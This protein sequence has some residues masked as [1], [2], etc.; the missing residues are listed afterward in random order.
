MTPAVAALYVIC[1][2]AFVESVV[3][4]ALGMLWLGEDADAWVLAGMV[5]VLAS[6]AVAM[7]PARPPRLATP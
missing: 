7:W 2:L 4:V 1:C 3:A 6:T 5:L